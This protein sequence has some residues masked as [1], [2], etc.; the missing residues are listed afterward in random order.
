MSTIAIS[1]LRTSYN[2]V[3]QIIVVPTVLLLICNVLVLYFVTNFEVDCYDVRFCP[4][5]P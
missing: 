5:C 3:V 2:A 1:S 4:L